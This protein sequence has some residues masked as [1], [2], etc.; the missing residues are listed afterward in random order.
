MNPKAFTQHLRMRLTRYLTWMR[1][2]T[3]WPSILLESRLCAPSAAQPSPLGQSST[4]TWKAVAWRQSRL[5]FLLRFP[6]PFLLL[7][8]RRCTSFLALGLHLGAGRTPPSL[9]PSPLNISYQTPTPTLQPA[10]IQDIES[11]WLSRHSSWSVCQGKRSIQC[12]LLL[13]SGV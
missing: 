8:P 11:P 3:K 13:K 7:L 9:S 4:T 1:A 5:L 6:R 10:L 2:L 12:W